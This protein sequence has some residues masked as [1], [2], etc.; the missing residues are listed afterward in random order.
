MR[1]IFIFV[2]LTIFLI[3]GCATVEV[4]REATKASKIIESSVKKIFKLPEEDEKKEQQILVEKQEITK[5]DEEKEK[6]EEKEQQILVEKQEILKEQ[7]K[8]STVIM[9]QKEIATIDLLNKTISELNRIIGQPNLIREDRKT[10][11]ARFDSKNCRLFVF[12]NSTLKTP[13]VEYYELR[14]MAG[15]LIDHEKSIESC[16]KEIKTG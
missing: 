10:T 2:I 12:M 5:K 4:A 7:K 9:K 1:A 8:I 11:T 16:F 15:D 3:T 14:G 13:I 6:G